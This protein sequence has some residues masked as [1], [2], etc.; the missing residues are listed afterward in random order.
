M[1]RRELR[2]GFWRLAAVFW[3]AGALA[4]LWWT[5][6]ARLSPFADVCAPEL[7]PPYEECFTEEARRLSDSESF[8]E[9]MLGRFKTGWEG[10]DPE[11]EVPRWETARHQQAVIALARRVALWT[12]AVWGPF[13]LL[14]WAFSG[15]RRSPDP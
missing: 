14:A 2:K 12:L 15:F 6:E 1:A 9:R 10:I 13:Y 11:R 5:E 8:T 4:L 7:D 3:A